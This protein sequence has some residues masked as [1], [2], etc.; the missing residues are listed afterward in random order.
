MI[1][2][3][4][5]GD[6]LVSWRVIIVAIRFIQGMAKCSSSKP[7]MINV[8]YYSSFLEGTEMKNVR[9]LLGSVIAIA[10]CRHGDKWSPFPLGCRRKLGSMGC[11]TYLEMG[12]ELGLTNPLIPTLTFYQHFLS[13]TSKHKPWETEKKIQLLRSDPGL[14]THI[15]VR[16]KATPKKVTR[17]KTC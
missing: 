13:G 8:P 12:D 11:F 4:P 9:Q 10:R 6:M 14:I 17:K 5:R 15:E 7:R 2:L 1:F 16:N 3:F